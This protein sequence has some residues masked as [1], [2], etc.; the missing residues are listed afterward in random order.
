MAGATS[1]GRNA[2]FVD[3]FDP[4]DQPQ[5]L[6]LASKQE[7]ADTRLDIFLSSSLEYSRSL[8]QDWIKDGRVMVDCR[9]VKS[10]FKLKENHEILI[11]I[12]P[13]EPADPQPDPS[14][15]IDVVFEDEHILVLN[16]QRGLVVHPGIGNPDG[17]LV[18]A[19][20]AHAN[21][22]S[23][24]RGVIKPGIVHRLD[25]NTSG[26]MVTAKHD[27][28]SLSLQN[29]FRDRTVTK[30]Y[31]AL[32]WGVPHPKRG[33]IHQP[34]ARNPRDRIKM[35]VVQGGKTA[36]SDF[37]VLEDYGGKH[38][39]VEVHIHTGRTHQIR[40]HL[41]WLG[42]PIVG[43]PMYGKSRQSFGLC[44][45][46]LHCS[47]LGITHPVGGKRLDFELAPPEDFEAAKRQLES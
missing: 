39:L 26:L 23:G 9:Q 33:R 17:T 2:A 44:G 29:Q 13:L 47:R 28:A 46:A 19:L 22:W 8:I 41:A 12:P 25:K 6:E 36:I 37:E 43:D 31:H 45:Q 42:F 14:I 18:N 1:L 24:I 38:A 35:A 16:K 30:I 7:H 5:I 34:L 15:P 32:V 27:V 11:E 20:L 40:V 3:P 10:S 4:S 21:D